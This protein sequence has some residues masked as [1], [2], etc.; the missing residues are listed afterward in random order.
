MTAQFVAPFGQLHITDVDGMEGILDAPL[1]FYSAEL[2]MLVVAPTYMATDFASI[3]RGLWNV[4]PKRGK[5]DR[6]AV[7]HDAGYRGFLANADGRELML[8]KA[9]IDRLFLEAMK[10]CGV[11]A[12]S[13]NAMYRAVSWFGGEAFTNAR[14]IHA[15]LGS[16]DGHLQS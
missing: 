1:H 11:G 10:A 7:L 12:F 2:Q 4:F 13:R 15:A 8:P 14:R 9:L 3:P 5:H 6:A 16:T